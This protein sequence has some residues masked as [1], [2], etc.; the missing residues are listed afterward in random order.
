LLV[1]ISVNEE[2]H[3]EILGVVESAKEDLASWGGF[4][5]HEGTRPRQRPLK[6]DVEVQTT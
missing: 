2:N 4:L 3:Q 1:A 5:N 6:R